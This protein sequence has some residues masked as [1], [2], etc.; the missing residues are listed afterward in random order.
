MVAITFCNQ[1]SHSGSQGSGQHQTQQ[2]LPWWDNQGNLLLTGSEL[3]KLERQQAAAVYACAEQA[4]REAIPKLL[5]TGLS[6]EQVAQAL[7]LP[8]EDVQRLG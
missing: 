5:A 8:V 2:W 1:T 7:S 4:Q 3:V 6:I